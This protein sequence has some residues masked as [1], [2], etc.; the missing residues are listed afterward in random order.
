MIIA[1]ILTNVVVHGD[2][3]RSDQ[4]VQVWGSDDRD[5]FPNRT[6]QVQQRDGGDATDESPYPKRYM[7]GMYSI[8]SQDYVIKEKIIFLGY[9][10][11]T[12]PTGW[13]NPSSTA[14]SLGCNITDYEE[15]NVEDMI[16]F[17]NRGQCSFSDKGIRAADQGAAGIVIVNYANQVVRMDMKSLMESGKK[18]VAL[19]MYR[20]TAIEI[21]MAMLDMNSTFYLELYPSDQQM[22]LERIIV[23]IVSFSFLILLIIS[24]IW[25]LVYYFQ[26][27]RMLH[28]QYAAQ[29][30]QEKQMKKAFKK[31]KVETL[32]SSSELVQN[33]D[34][35]CCAICID[36]FEAGAVVRHL[37]CKHVYHKKCIDPWLTEKGTCPQCKADILKSLGLG[38]AVQRPPQVTATESY[39]STE[40]V[41]SGDDNVSEGSQADAN[42]QVNEA[43]TDEEEPDNNVEPDDDTR[44]RSEDSIEVEHEINVS[45]VKDNEQANKNT[46]PEVSPEASSVEQTD[47]DALSLTQDSTQSDTANRSSF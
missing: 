45:V 37:T 21:M 23:I 1:F 35:A 8:G 4:L 36:D 12:D 22:G 16:V 38:E 19:S 14:S 9:N 20:S 11:S 43:F 2:Y 39:E 44:S 17:V 29:R 30:K 24:L 15:Q 26:R 41:G 7:D 27:F 25:V 33:H 47:P 34:E 31:M 3:V 42:E 13:F 18:I 40:N 5:N 28:R 32:N 46:L 10:Q 6:D